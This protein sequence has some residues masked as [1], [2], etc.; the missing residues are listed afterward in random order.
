MKDPWD[1]EG[2]DPFRED[3]PEHEVVSI[4]SMIKK[5][6]IEQPPGEVPPAPAQV[7][8]GICHKPFMAKAGWFLGKWRYAAICANCAD[9]NTLPTG[10]L[11]ECLRPPTRQMECPK[12]G[13]RRG[14]EPTLRFNLWHYELQCSM[15]GKYAVSVYRIKRKCVSCPEHFYVSERRP[16]RQCAKCVK[17]AKEEGPF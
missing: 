13:I 14:I 5:L 2:Y 12:C 8:C 4:G 1:E 7:Q 11:N 16:I 15:C 9:G 10:F 3:Y 6:G 17:A